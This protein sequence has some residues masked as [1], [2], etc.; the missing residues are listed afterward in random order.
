MPTI[1]TTF[2]LERTPPPPINLFICSLSGE[3]PEM[4]KDGSPETGYFCTSTATKIPTSA[5]IAR[6]L[7]TS[8]RS[9]E[10]IRTATTG[11][12]VQIDK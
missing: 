2:I 5:L 4:H 6:V 3:K 11:S 7:F 12:N 10:K 1:A 9:M 8:M